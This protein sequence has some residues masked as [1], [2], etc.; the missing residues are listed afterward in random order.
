MHIAEIGYPVG[1]YEGIIDVPVQGWPGIPYKPNYYHNTPA[2]GDF[3]TKWLAQAEGS[4]PREPVDN[5]DN[6]ALFFLANYIY[7]QKGFYPHRR[8]VPLDP[9]KAPPELTAT[10][11]SASLNLASIST[12]VATPAPAG[13]KNTVMAGSGITDPDDPFDREHY[14]YDPNQGDA[15]AAA[16][17]SKGID[18]FTATSTTTSTPPSTIPATTTATATS[19][20]SKP[21]PACT[22]GSLYADF[23]KCSDNCPGSCNENAGQASITCSCGDGGPA[24]TPPPGPSPTKCLAGS[25]ANA[26]NCFSSCAHR[27]CKQ[28]AEQPV[29]CFCL[30]SLWRL[31][32]LRPLVQSLSLVRKGMNDNVSDG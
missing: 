18:S 20:T 15:A 9:T 31:C 29:T 17:N 28:N 24:V 7:T 22:N 10:A 19:T 13:D 3:F 26:D 8:Q 21:P 6:Y 32:G 23:D 25:Y 5:A 14:C 2:Y 12:E 30:L 11:T 16:V 27:T 1:P 4:D